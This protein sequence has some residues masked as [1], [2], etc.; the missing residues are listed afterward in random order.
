MIQRIYT[1]VNHGL[2]TQLITV[3][4]DFSPALPAVIIVG[5]PDKAVQ[6]SKERIRTAL[7]QSNFEFPLGKIT[8]NLAPAD[9]LKTGTNFDLPIAISILQMTGYIK[10]TSAN[11]ETTL[12]VGELALDGSLRGVNGIL[13]ICLWARK[14]NYTRVFIPLDNQVEASLIQG[15]DIYVASNLNQIVDF[16]NQKIVLNPV[17]PI[18]ITQINN[19]FKSE[20]ELY[21]NDMAYIRGQKIAKRALE[22]AAAGGHNILLIGSPGSGKTLLARSYPT[23][24]PRM[25]EGEILEATEIHS[26]AGILDSNNIINIRPFRAPHHTSSHISLVGGGTKLRPGEVSLSHRGVLFLDEFPEFKRESLEALRQP[27]EDGFVQISRAS[28]SVIYP[29]KFYLVAAANPTPSGFDTND[30]DWANKPQNKGSIARY[31][32]KFSGPI[33]DRIDLHIEVNRPKQEELQTQVLAESSHQI[34][35]RVQKARD[36]QLKRFDSLNIFSNSEMNLSLIQKHCQL[37]IVSQKLI[38]QAIDKYKLSARSYMKILKLT[39]TI[40]DLDNS[41]IILIQHLAESLQYRPKF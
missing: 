1:A 23:I 11:Y 18:D 30:P 22:I 41:D 19:N 29:A 6:E 27:L 12:F 15:I 38:T 34:A 14:N 39:R 35:K 28:G 36:K 4:S 2:Q 5:L 10:E 26:V 17:E 20:N 33:M 37:D 9:V 32:S 25:M 8:I 7:K 13:S 40:A 3:E 21:D 16:L 31:Q 24:L